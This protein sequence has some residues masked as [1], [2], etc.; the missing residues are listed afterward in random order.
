MDLTHVNGSIHPRFSSKWTPYML[1]ILW[2]YKFLHGVHPTTIYIYILSLIFLSL[3]SHNVSGFLH[4]QVYPQTLFYSHKNLECK[5]KWCGRYYFLIMT[6][7]EHKWNYWI[8]FSS[9]VNFKRVMWLEFRVSGITCL[10]CCWAP[11]ASSPCSVILAHGSRF[12]DV[13]TR[14]TQ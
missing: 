10:W 8:V 4:K 12:T 14:K 7:Q 3:C 2:C 5:N 13:T 1:L 11:F 9:T 6:Y